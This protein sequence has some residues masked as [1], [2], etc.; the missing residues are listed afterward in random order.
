MLPP[1]GGLIVLLLLGFV[2]FP[3]RRAMRWSANYNFYGAS[4]QFNTTSITYPPCQPL[5]YSVTFGNSLEPERSY[6]TAVTYV[7]TYPDAVKARFL[8]ANRVGLSWKDA[9]LSN[10]VK[11]RTAR[12]W[13]QRARATGNYD[14]H[15][16]RRGGA[17]DR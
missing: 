2:S 10:G 9:A 6:P 11:E 14:V 5:S 12:G 3:N 8:H 17:R 1:R 16:S 15:D 7:Q 13:V 4:A